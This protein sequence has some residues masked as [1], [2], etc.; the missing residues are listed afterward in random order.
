MPLVANLLRL[1]HPDGIVRMS[2]LPF[3][4]TDPEG[5]TWIG[6]GGVLEISAR[7]AS[8]AQDGGSITVTWN[9]ASAALEA[10][11]THPT[12]IRSR[13]WIA[14]VWINEDMTR[15]FGPVNAW[16]GLVETPEIN[17]DPARPAIRITAQSVMLDLKN[18]RRVLLSPASQKVVDETDTGANWVAKL[19]DSPPALQGG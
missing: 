11:A 10:Y 12:L 13:L 6:G 5:A 8:D 1:D 14:T 16:A 7:G 9:G 19:P 15:E 17:L 2:T 4:W 3:D 18:P